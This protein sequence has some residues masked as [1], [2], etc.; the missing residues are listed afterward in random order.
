MMTVLAALA[1]LAA[2]P[3]KHNP[4]QKNAGP[5]RVFF[6]YDS[7]MNPC[8]KFA[9]AAALL[10]LAEHAAALELG[11]YTYLK[12]IDYQEFELDGSSLNHE[13][14][15]IPG[16][17]LSAAHKH[18][19][20][21]TSLDYGDVNYDGQLQSGVPH[22]TDTSYILV[23]GGYEYAYTLDQYQA[24]N[25][26]AGVSSHR[27]QRHILPNNGI[28]GAN[29]VYEWQQLH[30]GIRYRPESLFNLPLEFGLSFTKTLNGTVDINLNN[31]GFGS[32]QLVLGDEYGFQTGIRYYR[33]ISRQLSVGILLESSRWEFGR[34]QSKSFSNGINNITIAEPRSVSWH[35]SLG[36]EFKYGL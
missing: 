31:I 4:A 24:I 11:I 6:G 15:F 28:Q 34:S 33:E 3:S 19:A 8:Y 35:T 30:A 9:V 16:I 20:L 18:H 10:S 5:A 14:G 22:T 32:P 36:V 26:L 17:R 27:W 1:F 29:A 2:P 25:F 7:A 21:W 13:T 12:Y 23:S